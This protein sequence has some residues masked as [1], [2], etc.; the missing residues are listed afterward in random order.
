MSNPNIKPLTRESKHFPLYCHSLAAF[1]WS[2]Y[3]TEAFSKEEIWDALPVETK[4]LVED[5][6]LTPKKGPQLSEAIDG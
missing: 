4:R 6:I 2:G 3:R 1:I 5:F